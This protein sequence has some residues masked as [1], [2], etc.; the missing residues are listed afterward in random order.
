MQIGIIGLPLSSKTT[1]FNALTR[2]NAPTATF[3]SGKFEVH[4]AVVDVPDPRVDV[5]SGMFKPRKTIYARVQYSDIAGLAKGV[6]EKGGLEGALLNEI[7]KN[8]ALLL[9]I[10][11]FEDEN[12]PHVEG[13]VN[14]ARDLDILETELILSDLAIVERRLERLHASLTKGGSTPVEREQWQKEQT[15]LNQC[16]GALEDGKPARDL[17]IPAHDQRLLRSLALLTLKPELIVLNTGDRVVSDATTLAGREHNQT[18]LVTL[19]GRLEMELAQMAPEE[20]AEYMKE[21]GISEPGLARM[22]RLSYQLL[23]LQSFFTVGEDEVRA[24]TVP[25]GASALDAAGVIHSD[26]ARGF[27]RAEVVAYQ[28]LI[29]CGGMNE[30]KKRGVLRLEGK[31]YVVQDGDIVHVRF[32]V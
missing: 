10:R 4:N 5:L 1:I 24:W 6:G 9:V 16:K 32:A 14:P 15:L 28:D 22:I 27:I 13:D 3:S 25:I 8:D 29:E 18:L 11:A 17:D 21:F 23:G 20:A 7:A 2:G 31:E 26:L 30:A 12:V 19:Q